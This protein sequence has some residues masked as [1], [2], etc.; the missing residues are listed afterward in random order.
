M[1]PPQRAVWV[2][3]GTEHRI[4]SKSPFWLTT[5]YIEP[6]LMDIAG[7]PQVVAISP[8][9]NELLISASTFGGNYPETG[10]QARLVTVLL[11]SLAG[12]DAADIALPEAK[13]KRLLRITEQ[14]LA[15]PTCNKPLAT[16]AQHAGLTERTAARLFLRDTGMTFGRWRQ[17]MRL[18]LAL[19]YLAEGYSVARTATDVG[20]ADTSSFI[21]AFKLLFGKTPSSLLR[22]QSVATLNPKDDNK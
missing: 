18:L 16:L 11:D 15:E 3:S 20:Y 2:A 8:L 17:Q 10:P 9:A 19:Q 12:L 14:L 6:G 21:A 4:E 1:V 22:D 5:C 7:L 13:D